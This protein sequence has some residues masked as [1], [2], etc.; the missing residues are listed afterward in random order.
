[1]LVGWDQATV[2]INAPPSS[3]RFIIFPLE[4]FASQTPFRLKLEN[5][6]DDGVTPVKYELRY[7]DPATGGSVPL[8]SRTATNEF[9]S[10][11]PPVSRA[12]DGYELTILAYIVDQHNAKAEARPAQ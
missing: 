2:S 12:E 1:V 7:I 3:G 8:V 10:V 5:W 4:G 9:I 6:E 11:I